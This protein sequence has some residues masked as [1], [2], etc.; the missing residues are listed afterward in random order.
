MIKCFKGKIEK[1]E[2][3]EERVNECVEVYASAS[4]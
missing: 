1:E 4:I 2:K 3:E